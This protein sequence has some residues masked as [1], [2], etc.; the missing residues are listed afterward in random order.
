VSRASL[1]FLFSS[2]RAREEELMETQIGR[3]ERLYRSL[4]R[5]FTV[6]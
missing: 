2:L 1:A 3:L 5:L 6:F 4:S